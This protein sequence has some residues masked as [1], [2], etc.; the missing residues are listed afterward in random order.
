MLFNSEEFLFAFL[1]VSIA[2]FYLLGSVSRTSAIRWVILVSLAFYAWWRPLNLLIITPSIAINFALAHVL[3]R[4]NRDEKSCR[5]SK[6]VLLLGILFNVAFLGFFKYTDFIA[7]AAN[8][9]FNTNFVLRHII[10]PLGISFITFQKIAFLIDVQAGRIRSFTLQDYCTFVLFFP[11]LIAGPIVHYREM[12]PQFHSASCRPDK[13]NL[14]VGITLLA[15]GLF[16]KVVL[17]DKIAPLVTPIFD[18]AAA[19]GRTSFLLAWIAA[20]G[21]TLQIYF[22]FS[23]YSDMALGAARLFGIRLPQNFDSPL[24]ARSIIDFWLRWHMTLTRFLTAYIYNPLVL[25]MTRRR[26]AKGQRG[27]GPNPTI[28][29]FINLLMVPTLITM[30]VSGLWHGAGYGFILWGL[31]HGVYLTVNHGWRLVAARTG[32]ERRGYHCLTRPAGLVLTFLSVVAA[33]VF[34]RAPTLAS[35]MD[36]IKGIIGLNGVALPETLFDRPGPLTSMLR[37]LGVIAEP[38]T[39]VDLA[40]TA[41]LIPLLMFIALAC[42]NTLQILNRYE[43]ALGVKPTPTKAAAGRLKVVEWSPSFS[44]A[45]AVSGAAAAAIVSIGGPSEFLY[46]QF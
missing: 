24:R 14:A 31:L 45:I 10:L 1:P 13:E 9:V 8:D 6:V 40:R 15:F 26:L 34:F 28:G 43:P 32:L 29:S 18:Q 5:A 41:I 27:L 46:W 44:W 3:L 19:G 37:G 23:G 22:D 16:K 12:M 2:G 21:F 42:P 33:M 30:F 20:I 25:W 35:A 17:A 36:L 7:G 4:L 39:N 11:Q 38:W